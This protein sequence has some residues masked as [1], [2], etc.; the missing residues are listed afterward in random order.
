MNEIIPQLSAINNG[1]VDASNVTV[2]NNAKDE[3]ERTGASPE[4][5]IKTAEDIA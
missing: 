3:I 1:I 4:T 2:F 5:E